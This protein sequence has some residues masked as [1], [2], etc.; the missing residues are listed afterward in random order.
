[1]IL[2][3]DVVVELV[4]PKVNFLKVISFW[5]EREHEQVWKTSKN[6]VFFC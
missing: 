4:F 6:R 5:L 2:K 3:V 1:M